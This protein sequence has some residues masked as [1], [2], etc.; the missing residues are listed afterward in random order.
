MNKRTFV[1]FCIPL[2]LLLLLSTAFSGERPKDFR[3]FKWG[4]HISE[5]P[6]LVL[7]DQ[8]SLMKGAREMRERL[9]Q[10]FYRKLS[11]DL[12]VGHGQVDSIEYVFVKDQLTGIDMRFKD[13]RQYLVFKSLFFDLYGPPNMDEKKGDSIIINT[14]HQ[15]YANADDEANVTLYWMDWI[16]DN[17]RSRGGVLMRWKGAL[18]KGSGL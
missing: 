7:K 4:T 15:W 6:G 14:E 2:M 10:I 13:Y 8:E 17:I 16:S 11:D 18:K 5:I 3:G 12:K 1:L 9:G